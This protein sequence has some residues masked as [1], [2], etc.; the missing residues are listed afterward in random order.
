[1]WN[2][3]LNKWVA[4]IEQHPICY[5]VCAFFLVTG[6]ACGAFYPSAMEEGLRQDLYRYF[7]SLMETYAQ[8]T[9]ELGAILLK[10]LADN[11]RLC[12]II[13]IAGY[14]RIGSPFALL[15]ISIKGFGIGFVVATLHGVYGLHAIGMTMICLLLQNLLYFPGYLGLTGASVSHSASLFKKGNQRSTEGYAR[16]C[17][18]FCYL[19]IA[20]M[21][22]E[23]FLMPFLT[24]LTCNL[25]L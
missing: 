10:T 24:K 22:V 11:I 8:A 18:P 16:Q 3:F 19:V 13:F 6:I 7:Q 15:C 17:L 21:I 2:R 1:M 5:A 25:F 4:Q 23:A 9:P 20:G 14:V 12:A